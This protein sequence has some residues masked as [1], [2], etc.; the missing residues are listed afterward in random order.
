MN[1]SYFKF[2]KFKFPLSALWS[3]GNFQISCHL[4]SDEFTILCNAV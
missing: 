2:I 1:W 3:S 4:K